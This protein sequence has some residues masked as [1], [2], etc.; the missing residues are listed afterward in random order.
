MSQCNLPYLYQLFECEALLYNCLCFKGDGISYET[1][2]EI[3]ENMKK[4]K[5]SADNIAFGSGGK[6]Y[7]GLEKF[8]VTCHNLE[9][10][11]EMKHDDMVLWKT[12][13]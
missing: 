13:P 10:S 7:T 12:S 6:V 2:T 8:L 11:L 5:W 1:L 3:L 9:N 4:H